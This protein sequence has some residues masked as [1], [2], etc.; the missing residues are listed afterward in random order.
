MVSLGRNFLLHNVTFLYFMCCGIIILSL[1]KKWNLDSS[2][3]G[4][5]CAWRVPIYYSRAHFLMN[6]TLCYKE[7]E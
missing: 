6:F 1:W 5:F 7:A 3:M 2:Q 4:K